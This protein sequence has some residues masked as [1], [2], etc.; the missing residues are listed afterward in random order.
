MFYL[1]T[2]KLFRRK[3]ACILLIGI[4]LLILIPQFDNALRIITHNEEYRQRMD[5]FEK[6]NG[7]LTDSGAEEFWKDY[8]G[9]LSAEEV[10]QIYNAYDHVYFEDKKLIKAENTFPDS[11]FSII[12][13]FYEEWQVFL[14]DLITYMQYIP[15][16]IAVVFSGIFTY[17]KTCGM[18]EIMLSAKNGRKTSTKAKLQLAFLLANSMFLVVA[19]MTSVQMFFLT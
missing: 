18:Q 9:I 6:H 1:E 8:Q 15:I 12:F 14:A 4:F 7:I 10:E 17:D 13:G 11:N 19:L 2:Y 16:F 5:I 3:L